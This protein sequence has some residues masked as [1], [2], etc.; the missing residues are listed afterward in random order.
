M[1]RSIDKLKANAA[2]DGARLK[3]FSK[4]LQ[5]RRISMP[6]RPVKKR[7]RSIVRKDSSEHSNGDNSKKTT[8]NKK[9]QRITLES[10]PQK[11]E[12]KE[13]KHNHGILTAKKEQDDNSMSSEESEEQPIMDLLRNNSQT[14]VLGV[15]EKQGAHGFARTRTRSVTLQPKT[16]KKSGS[17]RSLSTSHS[18]MEVGKDSDRETTSKMHP[19]IVTWLQS[20]PFNRNSLQKTGQCI[21]AAMDLWDIKE[22]QIE[23]N[24]WE[25]VERMFYQR[26]MEKWQTDEV[27]NRLAHF[28][29]AL[30]KVHESI[31]YDHTEEIKQ[32][33]KTMLDNSETRRARLAT[34]EGHFKKAAA[35]NSSPRPPQQQQKP[36]SSSSEQQQHPRARDQSGSRPNQM[37]RADFKREKIKPWKDK[38]ETLRAQVIKN[39][40]QT[41]SNAYIT[42]ETKAAEKNCVHRKIAKWTTFLGTLL[43]DEYENTAA[44]AVNGSRVLLK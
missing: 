7:K 29:V 2:I 35:K 24:P 4:E 42:K 28:V 3:H 34:V 8:P 32:A 39:I 21:S 12:K 5:M 14:R 44:L 41:A 9:K 37:S 26:T 20:F 15:R 19:T 23:P 6:L 13:K 27:T 38:I 10:R 43:E 22:K 11:Q 30:D 25:M 17:S 36:T 33:I 31:R 18:K 16:E 40:E 1:Q